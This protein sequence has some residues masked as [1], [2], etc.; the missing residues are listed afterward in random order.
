MILILTKSDLAPEAPITPE[1]AK[2]A[3]IHYVPGQMA[4]VLK[5]PAKQAA[6]LAG[7]VWF[8]DEEGKVTVAKSCTGIPNGTRVTLLNAAELFG[9]KVQVDT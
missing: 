7:T 4:M 1:Q 2:A 9:I 8:R 6:Q 5:E 3:G